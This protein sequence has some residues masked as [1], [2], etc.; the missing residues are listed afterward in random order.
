MSNERIMKLYHGSNKEIELD[1]NRAMY[2][3]PNIDVAKQYAF[4]LDDLGN[5]NEQSFIY[6][7]EIKADQVQIEEEFMYFDCIGYQ[8]YDNM[9]AIVYNEECEY[10]CLKN[11]SKLDLVENYD[12]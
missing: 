7:I 4:G 10:F 5:F 11:V 1:T 8:D 6:S 12:N 9:P 2:F 3:T